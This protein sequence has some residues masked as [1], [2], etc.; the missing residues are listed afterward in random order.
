M[1][2]KD[3]IQN[4]YRGDVTISDDVTYSIRDVIN[5]NN[6]MRNSQFEDEYFSD[7]ETKKTY[8]NA[9]L[10]LSSA[11]KRGSRL[12]LNEYSLT[13]I[14]GKNQ[15]LLDI[16]KLA[17]RNHLRLNGFIEKKNEAQDELVDMGHVVGKIVD[18][19]TRVVDLQNLVFRPDKP[20]KDGGCA[21]LIYMTYDEAKGEYGD[22]KN[23]DLIEEKFKTLHDESSPFLKFVEYW[24]I[25]E[26]EVDGK[27]EITKGC[28]KY[29]DD[30]DTDPDEI[31]DPTNWKPYVELDRFASPHFVK[32]QNKA[33]RKR[34][35][36]K[37]RAYPY[38]EESLIKIPGRSMGMGVYELCRPVQED[39]NEKGNY[40]RKFDM[41][42]L[43]GIL[44]HKI[45]QMRQGT[46]GEALTQEFIKRMETG[47]AVKIFND[48]SLDR[49]NLGSTTPDTLNMMNFLFELMRFMLGITPQAIGEQS[50]NRT[51][52]FAIIQ[53]QT[54]QS[55]YQVVKGKTARFFERLIQNFLLEDILEEITAKDYIAYSGE[56]NELKELDRFLAE[57]SVYSDIQNKGI[58]VP[59]E[60]TAN[61]IIEQ[62]M[63]ELEASGSIRRIDLEDEKVKRVMK[64]LI[65]NLDYIVEF[66]FTDEALDIATK[67]RT[68]IDV[69]QIQNPKIKA[70]VM[71]YLGINPKDIELTEGEK[72]K[73]LEEEVMK[74][75]ATEQAK[76]TEFINQLA[77]VPEVTAEG[78]RNV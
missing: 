7:N 28:I 32:C 21:E 45:G 25:D 16:V 67:I 27:K 69:D 39:Y 71:D 23:W 38:E 4:F 74:V 8:Y 22:N 12:K 76:D 40:K 37:R 30:S 15:K 46:K 63:R 62:K 66:H 55:T 41:I 34:F 2:V 42:A 77:Q 75:G 29:L 10:G 33:E 64:S 54:Q 44:V 5:K 31:K 68:L 18:G 60:A 72:Q 24:V 61:E 19:E 3:F 56:P 9:I 57:Q 1:N 47:A 78:T 52:S 49:L 26:F 11:L 6:Q 36:E 65:K 59:D 43:R 51:A 13:N 50:N 14:S 35:G 20:I 73:L 70:K 48:E 53:N 17:I 58:L